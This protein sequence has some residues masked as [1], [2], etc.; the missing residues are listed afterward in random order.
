MLGIIRRAGG[1]ATAR[2]ICL[3]QNAGL[4][5]GVYA[6]EQYPGSECTLAAGD[7]LLFYTDGITEA[8][9]K[10]HEQF[11]VEGLDEV[12]RRNYNSAEELLQALQ[13]SL[14]TFTGGQPP[15]TIAPS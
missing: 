2:S 7:T 5:L 15:T 11:G 4:P 13:Q 12:L 6:G 14:E 9:G 1:I 10:S 8:S 3:G